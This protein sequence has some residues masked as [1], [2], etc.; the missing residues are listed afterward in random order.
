MQS[1]PNITIEALRGAATTIRLKSYNSP[2]I[3]ITQPHFF[4]G[5]V[6]AGAGRVDP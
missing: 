1:Q 3:N 6:L 4:S 5:S 2:L